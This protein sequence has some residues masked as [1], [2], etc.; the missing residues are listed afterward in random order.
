MF[1]KKG[2]LETLAN[3]TR[4]HLHWNLFLIKLQVFRPAT[5]LKRNSNTGIF[6]RNFEICKNTYFEEYPRTTA[7]VVFFSNFCWTGF[8]IPLIDEKKKKYES[9]KLRKSK[10]C[11]GSRLYRVWFFNHKLHKNCGLVTFTKEIL[12]GKFFVKW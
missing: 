7:S 3:F 10:M 9:M 12:N 5:L 6:L 4:K 1:F 11:S 8:L 2:V